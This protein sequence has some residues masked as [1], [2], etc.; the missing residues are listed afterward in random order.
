M[1]HNL[2]FCTVVC[3][4]VDDDDDDDEMISFFWGGDGWKERQKKR[5]HDI[6][7]LRL[8][9]FSIQEKKVVVCG[10]VLVFFCFIDRYR[11]ISFHH[12]ISF[13]IRLWNVL[14]SYWIFFRSYYDFLKFN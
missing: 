2:V 9:F 4:C 11:Y 13:L 12:Y 7:D 10:F 5:K 8:G 3:C 6:I 14:S 1:F